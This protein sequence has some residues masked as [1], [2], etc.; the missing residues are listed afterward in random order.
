VAPNNKLQ[1]YSDV[2]NRGVL[3]FTDSKQHKIQYVVKD[4]FGNASTLVF[5]VKSHPQANMGGRQKPPAGQPGEPVFSYKSDNHFDRPNLKFEVP[6]E[7]VYDDFPFKYSVTPAVHGSY[8][9]VHHLQDQYTPLH[10]WCTLSLKT[11]NLPKS[12]ES[13]AVI[14]A[15]TGGN[16]FAARGGTWENGWITTKIRDFGSFTVTTDTEAPVIRAINVFPNKNVKKQSSILVKISDDLSGIKSYRGTMNGKWILMDYDEKSRL[17]TYAF[18]DMMK[19]GKNLFVLTVT[20]A[21]G[22]SS[23][24]EAALLH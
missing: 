20:D 3:N 24:Y 5:Y 21:V 23:R 10:T 16:K 11:V 2:K 18:D 15:V 9:E 7:A 12:L 4:A 22:N 1:V 13:K 17:L 19:P 6:S 8:S 14:V